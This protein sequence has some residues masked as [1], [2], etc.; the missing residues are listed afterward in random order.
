M[1]H[2][3][4]QREEYAKGQRE[5]GGLQ[6]LRTGGLL[7]HNRDQTDKSGHRG[8]KYR[9][10]TANRRGDDRLWRAEAFPLEPPHVVNEYQIVIDHNP[11]G[12]T[13]PGT[14][15]E[16]SDKFKIFIPSGRA[17]NPVS[18]DNWEGK[19]IAPDVAVDEDEALNVAHLMAVKKLLEKAD[20]EDKSAFYKWDLKEIKANQQPVNPE[21]NTLRSYTGSYGS[22][23]TLEDGQL[24]YHAY[25]D[26]FKLIP[27]GDDEFM[28]PNVPY[29]RIKFSKDRKSL[30]EASNLFP[31]LVRE[32]E[33]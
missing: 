20:S 7:G 27:M 9:P 8:Q 16:V 19:G 23:V 17:I 25:N 10:E 1:S 29:K 31:D 6:E 28:L 26:S 32:R 12:G 14:T 24:I 15:Y 4:E 13:N 5:Y 11:G 21:T 2:Y 3:D 33:K 22:K 18:G 30:T